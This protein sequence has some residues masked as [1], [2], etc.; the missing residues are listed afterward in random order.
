[1]LC[2]QLWSLAEGGIDFECDL[3]M[4][5]RT[6]ALAGSPGT[7]ALESIYARVVVAKRRVDRLCHLFDDPSILAADSSASRFLALPKTVAL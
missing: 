1:M 2:V 3:L 5:H 7:Q 6:I 4:C